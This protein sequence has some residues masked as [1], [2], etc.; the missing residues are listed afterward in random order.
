MAYIGMAL[1]S[2]GLHSHG[3]HSYALYSYID[4]TGCGRAAQ[5]GR[6]GPY[7]Q[8][9]HGPK[10]YIV[11]VHVI[12]AYVVMAH[13]VMAHVV[14]AYVLMAHIVMAHVVMVVWWP[15]AD[16]VG[17]GRAARLGR[18]GPCATY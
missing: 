1:Y 8:Y 11:M 7:G 4:L 5:L 3:L 12:L 9:S 18:R 15:G 17:C 16:A 10:Y 14:M 13:I 6:R 2:Y